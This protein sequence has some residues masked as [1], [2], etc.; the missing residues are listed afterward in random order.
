MEASSNP[1]L[2]RRFATDLPPPPLGGQA[3]TRLIQVEG[4]RWF[5]LTSFRLDDFRSSADA[6]APV[7]VV[8]A[9]QDASA[10]M[11]AACDDLYAN[12]ALAALGFLVVE[13]FLILSVRVATRRLESEIATATAETRAL[14]EQVSAMAERDPLTEL[15]N[16][17]AFDYRMD[18]A[19]ALADRS[20]TPLSLAIIDLDHFKAIN[21]TH[22]HNAGDRVIAR[23]A[24]LLLDLARASDIACRWGGEEFVLALPATADRQALV[25]LERLRDSLSACN[26]DSDE[27]PPPFTFSAGIAQ[28][29]RGDSLDTLLKRADRALYRAKANGRDRI[30]IT[31]RE[32]IVV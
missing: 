29:Q 24:R 22:G 27:E 20:G 3:S 13:L 28:W 10:L 18:A 23:I 8:A 11:N 25:M 15:F 2:T 9:W 19:I 17:R 6:Q 16:R 4:G 7:G 5:G 1:A 26:A 12:V 21:D 30:E 31:T 32:Q 14:L